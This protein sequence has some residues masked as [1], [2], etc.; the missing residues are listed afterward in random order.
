M[1]KVAFLFLLAAC[2]GGVQPESVEAQVRYGRL[3]AAEALL[4]RMDPAHPRWQDL[5]AQI[6][7][8]R[9]Q[10]KGATQ[11]CATLRA[12]R[13]GRSL[14][15]VLADLDALARGYDDKEALEIVLQEKSASV[16]WDAD[17]RSQVGY[18]PMRPFHDEMVTPDDDWEDRPQTHGFTESILLDVD[19]ATK[20]GRH[21]LAFSLVEQLINDLPAHPSILG[22]KLIDA[23]DRV[24]L[25][26]NE[27][28]RRLIV[29]AESAQRLRGDGA[30]WQIIAGEY[31]RFPEAALG[32]ELFRRVEIWRVL[33]AA[34]PVPGLQS[35]SPALAV[36]VGAEAPVRQVSDSEASARDALIALAGGAQRPYR[37][38]IRELLLDPN[39]QALQG[40]KARLAGELPKAV[41]LLQFASRV[42]SGPESS[43]YRRREMECRW[44]AAL[45]RVWNTHHAE[46][47]A[48]RGISERLRVLGFAGAQDELSTLASDAEACLGILIAA[49]AEDA[50]K[51]KDLGLTILRQHREGGQLTPEH[52]GI[53]IALA[54]GETYPE[55][56]YT[57]VGDTFLWTTEY[58]EQLIG[59]QLSMELRKMTKRRGADREQAWETLTGLADQYFHA[60]TRLNE[61]LDEFTALHAKRLLRSKQMGRLRVLFAQRQE[62]EEARTEALA[63]IFDTVEYFYPIPAA[64]RA[65]Y[66]LVQRRVDELV[67]VVRAIWEAP[68]VVTLGDDFHQDLA[69]LVWVLGKRSADHLPADLP[70]WVFLIEEEAHH[71][72]LKSFA[73][74]ISVK[75][76]IRTSRWIETYNQ[77]LWAVEGACRPMEA[78]Q[79]RVTNRYRRLLGRVSLAWDARL[80]AATIVHG[81]YMS[82]TGIFSHFEEDV[83]A[84]RTPY[85]RMGEQG[86][87][88][89]L[90]ENIHAGAGSPQGAHYGWTHSSGHHRA[91][92]SQSATEMATSVVGKYWTQNFGVGKDS[93]KEMD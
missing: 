43:R 18:R 38:S 24:L 2:G 32:G 25:A 17:R 44:L 80:Q 47:G 6:T 67:A 55:G 70:L 65:E 56:G 28:A 81:D 85:D 23:R 61:S 15:D 31:L 21:S 5:R 30:A 26:A 7:G 51:F 52:T 91:L 22:V 78:E 92:L 69:D 88:R 74:T 13:E 75:Q 60:E 42:T 53:L 93:R 87:D 84:R 83:P 76:E 63:L 64:R 48:L 10:R 89:G 20:R 29:Q 1:K 36:V 77:G 41:A 27:G 86:Y 46:G 71:L 12:H 58:E 72:D 8:V 40:E 11:A 50:P 62:L 45:S 35:G 19:A 4:Q 14:E 54:K 49:L 9:D 90:G 57:L 16:D 73:P 39:E 33:A 82:R 66:N 59:K 79:V 3:D 37:L 68:S 34:P